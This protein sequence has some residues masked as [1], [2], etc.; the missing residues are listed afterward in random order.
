MS[1]LPLL[2]H[3][4]KAVS[5]RSLLSVHKCERLGGP[6]DVLFYHF[7]AKQCQ[8]SF[9]DLVL[10]GFALRAIT[11]QL[12]RDLEK[13]SFVGVDVNFLS[14]LLRGFHQTPTQP[15]GVYRVTA[16]PE[17]LYVGRG[18]AANYFFA[19]GCTKIFE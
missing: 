2:S 17:V 11:Q 10:Q 16:S 6:L 15:S 14:W 9:F 8:Y 12:I 7:F 19:R 3:Y 1:L 5:L 13:D 18:R 4:L